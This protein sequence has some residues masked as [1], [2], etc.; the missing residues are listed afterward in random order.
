M[1]L[2]KTF[3]IKKEGFSGELLAS[4]YWKITNISGNKT[5]MTVTLTAFVSKAQVDNFAFSFVPDV[6]DGAADFIRQAY[7][8]AKTLPE[9]AN[10]EDS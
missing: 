2:L 7:I 9:F 4:A 6:S 1:A 5:Q 10:S 8:F 3:S